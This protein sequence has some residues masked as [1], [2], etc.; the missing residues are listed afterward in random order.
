MQLVADAIYYERREYKTAVVYYY[1]ARFTIVIVVRTTGR[2]KCWER[3][4]L[5]YITTPQ[6]TLFSK[7][8]DLVSRRM[9]IGNDFEN[10]LKKAFI[11]NLSPLT[12]LL[13]YL[14]DS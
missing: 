8:T 4:S 1:H 5:Y 13:M 11:F 10:Y 7:I 14:R 3:E 2:Q 6:S 12:F 9:Q